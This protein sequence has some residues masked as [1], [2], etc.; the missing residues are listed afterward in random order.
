MHKEKEEERDKVNS[1]LKLMMTKKPMTD[2]N[3]EAENEAF[4][5][6]Q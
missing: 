4:L 1:A 3:G 5:P 2:Q 6:S